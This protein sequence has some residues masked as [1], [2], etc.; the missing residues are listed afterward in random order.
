G[1]MTRKAARACPE[2]G[3]KVAAEPVDRRSFLRIAGG[4][5][6]AAALLRAPA[7]AQEAK[8]NKTAE[9][10]IKELYGS[11]NDSQKK[12][13]VGTIDDPK[14]LQ[15][16]NAA[17][18]TKIGDAYSKPQQEL[19]GRIL[20]SIAADDEGWKLLS[21]D[22]TWDGT[23]AFE[24]CGANLFGDPS[25]KFTWVFS[26]HHLTIRCDGNTGE[27]VAFG[28][29]LYYGHSPNGYSDKNLFFYQTKSALAVFEALTEAQRKQAS[30]TDTPG[31]GLPSIKFRAPGEARPGVLLGELSKEAQG[32]VEKVMMDLLSPYRKTDAERVLQIVKGQGGMEKMNL[33][34]YRDEDSKPKQPWTFWRLEGSGFVWN[35]R[36][37]PHVHTFVSISAKA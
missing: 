3:E 22:G 5:A 13:V 28:G 15:I 7:W 2:C 10:L 16:F 14:R 11:L 36:V 29:P 19:V 33:A 30:L 18:G 6:A 23:K 26:G 21:R 35:F 34:F 20:R 27:G 24:N 12:A 25:G 8:S 31:E 17:I 4:A 9:E 37:L 1:I 32:L